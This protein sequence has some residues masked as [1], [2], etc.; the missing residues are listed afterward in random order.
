MA[1][2]GLG[3]GVRLFAAAA[4]TI[5]N[6]KTGEVIG[7]GATHL[8]SLY[9]TESARRGYTKDAKDAET[10]EKFGATCGN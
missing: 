5:S 10:L 4:H 2:G 8:T 7:I 1:L 6:P 3:G 9:L